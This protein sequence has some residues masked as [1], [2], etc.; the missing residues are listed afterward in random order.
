[1]HHT[2]DMF[3]NDKLLNFKVADQQYKSLVSSS[4]ASNNQTA[5]DQSSASSSGLNKNSY[6]VRRPASKSHLSSDNLRKRYTAS[7]SITTTL[8]SR[9]SIP[10]EAEQQKD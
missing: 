7:G 1:M 10:E 2:T 4:I 9:K 3:A 5:R 6:I 8:P